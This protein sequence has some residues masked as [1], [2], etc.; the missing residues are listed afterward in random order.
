M[1]RILSIAL[2]A[3][4]LSCT[5]YQRLILN[6]SNLNTLLNDSCDVEIM[7]QLKHM[8]DTTNNLEQKNPDILMGDF[9]TDTC[10][11]YYAKELFLSS[12][13]DSAIWLR[14]IRPVKV[15]R[16]EILVGNLY[17]LYPT[18]DPSIIFERRIKEYSQSDNFEGGK[19]VGFTYFLENDSTTIIKL[20]TKYY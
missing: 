9:E 6:P 3:T 16:A 5:P 4:I 8:L 11:E 19:Y 20:G 13:T 18:K 2:L 17:T 10:C 14:T 12:D 1:R 15:G 7:S